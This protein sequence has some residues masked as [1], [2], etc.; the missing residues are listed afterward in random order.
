[1][2]LSGFCCVLHTDNSLDYNSLA[3]VNFSESHK[4]M[5]LFQLKNKSYDE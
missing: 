2:S 1:M 5:Q 3:L 4:E